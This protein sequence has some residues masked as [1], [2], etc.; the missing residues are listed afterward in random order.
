MDELI[1]LLETRAKNLRKHKGT[2]INAWECETILKYAK[3]IKEDEEKK[4]LNL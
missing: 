1:K 4:K 3:E 2:Q